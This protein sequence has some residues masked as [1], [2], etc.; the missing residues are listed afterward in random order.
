[1][2]IASVVLMMTSTSAVVIL[3]TASDSNNLNRDRMRAG[4]LLR[5]AIEAT[6]N[7]KDTNILRSGAYGQFCWNFLESS[8]NKDCNDTTEKNVTNFITD[9][10]YVLTR[11]MNSYKWY[12]NKKSS[13]ENFSSD[14]KVALETQV[15]DPTDF[16]RV[17]EISYIKQDLTDAKKIPTVSTYKSGNLMIAKAS[18]Y[19]KY[20]GNI[21]NQTAS[22][23][24]GF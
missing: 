19:W 24:L 10:R 4:N 5:E 17:I 2:I 12:L 11:D 13:S 7:I 3:T 18:V 23:R 16:Y 22:V 8:T 14:Y 9:G 20:K 6:H 15:K 21:H 1:V